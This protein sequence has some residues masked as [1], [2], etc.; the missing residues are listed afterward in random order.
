VIDEEISPGSVY[1]SILWYPST[2]FFVAPSSVDPFIHLYLVRLAY[3]S[4]CS[5]S[6]HVPSTTPHVSLTPTVYP[7]CLLRHHGIPSLHDLPFTL[8]MTS[9][10]HFYML[11][12]NP[13]KESLRDL[14]NLSACI[15]RRSPTTLSSDTPPYGED[16]LA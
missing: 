10:K 3:A 2:S 15:L 12:L 14:G 7:C 5:R 11:G 1:P 9:H 6:C 8:F 16:A 4:Y 13:S